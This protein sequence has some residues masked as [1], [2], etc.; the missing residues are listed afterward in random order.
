MLFI[1]NFILILIALFSIASKAEVIEKI[2]ILGLDVISRGTVLNYLPLEVGDNINDSQLSE[3]KS[4]ILQTNFFSNVDVKINDKSLQIKLIEN[5]VIKYFEFKNFEED[6]VLNDKVVK[7]IKDNFKFNI[8]DIF[9]EN[10]RNE[11]INSLK[12]LY[13]SKG[14]YQSKIQIKQNL[15]DK[16]R[17]GIEFVF[18]EGEQALIDSM[19]IIGS[20]YFS[21]D[22]LLDLFDIGAPD[23]FLI[24]YFTE[25]DH[26]STAAFEAGIEKIKTKYLDSGFLDIKLL[27]NDFIYDQQTNS[28]KI[29]IPLTEGTQYR[30]DSINFSGNILGETKTYLES[31]FEIK[32]GDFF[33]RS[34]I[35]DGIKKLDVFY[36]NNG[37]AYSSIDSQVLSKIDSDLITINISINPDT[38]VYINRII[39]TGN[40][41]TQDDVIRRRL[42]LNEGTLYSKED[43]DESIKRIKRLGYFSDVNYELKR[44]I[45]DN[46]L[47]IIFN[48]EEAKTGEISIGLSHSNST[49]A[50]L[51]AGISQNNILGTGNT[52]R[53]SFSNSDAL[54][55][56]SFYFLNPYFNNLGHTLSYGLFNK[57]LD[58]A[59]LDT[60]SY[61]LDESGLNLGYGVP[62]SINSKLFGEIG[63]SNIDLTCGAQLANVEEVTQCASNKDIDAVISLN[64]TSDSLNDYFFP[65]DGSKTSIDFSVSLPIADYKYYKFESSIKDYTPILNDKIFKLSTR[66]NLASGY[67]GDEL[68]FFK[69][70]YEGGSSSIRGFDFNSL[71]AKY[72]ST[73]KPKGGE[74]SFVSSLG[75]ASSLSFAGIDNKNMRIS[76]FVDAGNISEKKSDFKI[77]ELRASTGIQFTWLTPVGP[78]GLHYATPLLKKSNDKTKSLSFELGTS[79]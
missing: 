58:A 28:I 77:D 9:S 67:G 32:N 17:I 35:V 47:D 22:D 71:G 19:E 40:T 30:F 54:N 31:F 68:P 62:T 53:A 8:G 72:A 27:K 44:H 63:I 64:H 55:E 14:F 41:T 48:V 78:I 6:L 65:T 39:F 25:R 42:L 45:N 46:K 5:P 73:D 70:Y 52:L 37:Y 21:E 74:L 43:L 26:F 79:F 13:E 51:N 15:D 1:K 61:I 29:K 20:K 38:R 75:I 12:E 11:I 59:N 49:G 2:E 7:S 33:K 50:A 16:N 18:D 4:I 23:F 36:K 66:F 10:K 56:T 34:L 60:S 76:A 3:I 57:Q 69:R 24:N